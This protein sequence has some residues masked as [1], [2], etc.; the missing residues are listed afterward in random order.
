MTAPEWRRIPVVF[1]A[2]SARFRT[3]PERLHLLIGGPSAAPRG[4][5]GCGAPMR[6]QWDLARSTAA[7]RR[8]LDNGTGAYRLGSTATE[9]RI[10][11][12]R[13]T[14]GG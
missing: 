10:E 8:M 7:G 14:A 2:Y 13:S 4:A 5:P 6:C 11:Y 1:S 9:W 12:N 3:A